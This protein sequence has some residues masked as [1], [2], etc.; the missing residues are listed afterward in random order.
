[1][2]TKSFYT[3]K[4]W[5]TALGIAGVVC[6]VLFFYYDRHNTLSSSLRSW[7]VPGVV[8]AILFMAVLCVT[9]IPSESLL[10]LYMRIYGVGPGV[11]YSWLGSI[12]STI[13]VY[14]VARLVGTPLLTAVLSDSRFNVIDQWIRKKGTL[15]LLVVRLLPI[16]GFLVSY[17]V[18]TIPSVGLWRFTWTAAVSVIPYYVGAALIY[19]GIATHLVTWI[20]V[21]LSG[22][23]AFWVLV[24]TVRKKWLGQGV[25]VTDRTR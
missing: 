10:I 6:V 12:V 9:P 24:Y 8:A 7:G 4:T 3:K 14:V 16:P 20:A 5:T 11:L 18:G 23:V 1:M 21:G 22:M 15:G 19:L 25:R 13:I 17:V 2:S